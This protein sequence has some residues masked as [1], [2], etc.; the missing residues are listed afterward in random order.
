MSPKIQAASLCEAFQ[1]TAA[2]RPDAIALRTP[3]GGTEISWSAYQQR[4]ERIARGLAALGVARGDTVGIMMVNRPE[5]SLVD[6][7]ALHL[8][9]TPFSIYNTSAPEQIDYL[10]GNAG[11]RVV[12]CEEQFVPRLLD[13]RAQT[14]LEHVVCIDAKPDGTISLEELEAGGRADFD[15]EA[16]WRAV[17][18]GDVATLIYTSGTTG[19]PKG[20]ELTHGNLIAELQ[21]ITRLL[22]IAP[23]DRGLSYLPSAHVADRLL[24]H[25]FSLAIGMQVT[26]LGEPSGL[27][28]ALLDTRP[29][30]FGGVPRIWEKLM[31]GLQAAGVSD[32]TTLDDAQRRGALEKLGMEQV[33]TAGCGAA[34]VPTEV[35]EYF[36]ALGIP[37]QEVW[38][39]SE[40]SGIATTNPREDLRIG[41]VG[42]ALPG[43]ELKVA[44]D[45]ELL[46]R[47][48]IVMRGY[49]NQPDKTAE[50]I[51][52]DGWL[53]TGD[54][55]EI[56]DDGYVRIVDR[57]KELIINAAGKNMSPANIEQKL[58]AASPLIGQAVTIGD[59]RKYNVALLVLD[60]DNAAA[61]AKQH[62]LADASAAALANDPGIR[63]VVERAVEQANGR[64][65]RVE[66]IKRFTILPT[67]W[68]PGGDELT[69][70]SKLKRKPISEK[71]AAEIE[72]LYA[73]S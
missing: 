22:P 44:D 42:V 19:P 21:A 6:T 64:M 16:A 36:L 53:S 5:F 13:A 27:V 30:F 26:S 38:G 12:V 7:A 62:G 66:Q 11:N 14:N 50:T 73:D 31:A 8:G 52:A 60:P 71:Y 40:L 23:D 3:G 2:E 10:F 45:G 29:T 46:C 69:P 51:D 18:E 32:P 28:P 65:A 70:T 67:D 37:V 47:G 17:D 68:A 25:Y 43:V 34:P 39:M 61:Y 58:K 33:R 56:D 20:V 57:K 41:S 48:P 72:A 1:K 35:L 54:I 15:F 63:D 59:G 24:S 4:V 9:A 49:R 55:A